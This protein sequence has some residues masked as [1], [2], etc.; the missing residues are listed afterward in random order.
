MLQT[1]YNNIGSVSDESN[2]QQL[3]CSECPGSH[4]SLSHL[5]A[6]TH[7]IA[8]DYRHQL[9]ND[10]VQLLSTLGASASAWVACHRLDL[11]HVLLQYMFPLPPDSKDSQRY[12]T[13]LMCGAFTHTQANQAV[14][15]IGCVSV[16]EKSAGEIIIHQKVRLLCIDSLTQ[17]Y[18]THKSKVGIG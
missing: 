12:I 17:F 16:D 10:I 8:V 4:L 14:R 11:L 7:S 3:P 2:V 6:C 15:F 5:S 1:Q 9:Q 13:Q 18:T